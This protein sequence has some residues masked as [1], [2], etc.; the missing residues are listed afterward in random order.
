MGLN[1]SRLCVSNN[2]WGMGYK[3]LLSLRASTRVSIIFLPKPRCFRT[4]KQELGEKL[5]P[6]ISFSGIFVI[7]HI[8]FLLRLQRSFV[9]STASRVSLPSSRCCWRRSYCT[10]PPL[11][12]ARSGSEARGSLDGVAHCDGVRVCRAHGPVLR[13]RTVRKEQERGT[14]MSSK[15]RPAAVKGPK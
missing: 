9:T 1:T 8:F 11:R 4:P 6:K 14:R 10:T 13:E 2:F 12:G 3:I 5:T 7:S 15:S